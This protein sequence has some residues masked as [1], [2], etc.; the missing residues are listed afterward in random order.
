[1][2]SNGP[3]PGLLRIERGVRVVLRIENP[4]RGLPGIVERA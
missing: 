1:M 4:L 3:A 2:I